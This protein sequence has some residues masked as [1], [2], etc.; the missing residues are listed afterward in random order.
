MSHEREFLDV[1][2]CTGMHGIIYGMSY[3]MELGMVTGA[4]GS[5]PIC[6]YVT[7]M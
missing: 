1:R 4:S 3:G 5:I 2:G 7:D 6:E